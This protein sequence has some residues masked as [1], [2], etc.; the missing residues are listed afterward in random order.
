M[1]FL[2]QIIGF[3][4]SGINMTVRHMCNFSGISAFAYVVIIL[5]VGY[6]VVSSMKNREE[7]SM[8]EQITQ[9]EYKIQA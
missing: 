2:K 5:F 7:K 8:L 9:E 6:I 1:I 4:S 3:A